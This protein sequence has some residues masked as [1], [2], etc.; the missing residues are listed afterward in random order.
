[1][2]QIK[3]IGGRQFVELPC[4]DGKVRTHDPMEAIGRINTDIAGHQSELTEVRIQI[5]DQQ[6]AIR[7]AILNG[8]DTQPHRNRIAELEAQQSDL[9]TSM[10]N[11]K[12][13]ADQVRQA[14]IDAN[15]GLM[16]TKAIATHDAALS[17]LSIEA[18]Q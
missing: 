12:R 5:S 3:T 1:M 9:A 11:A 2:I 18:F 13:I 6:Q 17:P 14:I 16:L 15:A 10:N 7:R 8:R 4:A